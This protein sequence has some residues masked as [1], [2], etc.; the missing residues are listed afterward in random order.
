MPW[1]AF[2][3]MPNMLPTD[4]YNIKLEKTGVAIHSFVE[5]P[6][7]KRA[8]KGNEWHKMIQMGEYTGVTPIL[9][10]GIAIPGKAL[11]STIWNQFL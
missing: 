8:R 10:L 6:G 3:I 4:F 7:L 1:I 5:G 2:K 11:I 9:T